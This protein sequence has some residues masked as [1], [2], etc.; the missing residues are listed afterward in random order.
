MAE[1]RLR[2]IKMVS[3]KYTGF[4]WLLSQYTQYSVWNSLN[5]IHVIANDLDY[6]LI[7]VFSKKICISNE[8][9][10]QR[11]YF[12]CIICLMFLH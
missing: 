2:V 1:P 10:L 11:T 5:K 3:Y 6:S 7:V 4:N 12:V 9:I 8:M